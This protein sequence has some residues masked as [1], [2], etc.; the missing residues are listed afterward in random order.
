V[1][2]RA[3]GLGAGS[4]QWEQSDAGV[5]A[6]TNGDV[7]VVLNFGPGAVALPDGAEVL[8]A[9]DESAIRSGAL[10]PD[11]AVWVRR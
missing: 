6:F 5:L 7:R 11:H 4:L 1:L 8:L 9:S 2:R 10:E 3:L